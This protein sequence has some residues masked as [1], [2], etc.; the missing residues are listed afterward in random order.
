[1]KSPALEPSCG[2][3][4]TISFSPCFNRMS[5]PALLD[6]KSCDLRLNWGIPR[7]G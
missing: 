5:S 7:R 1:L 4:R 2:V 3:P 6:T